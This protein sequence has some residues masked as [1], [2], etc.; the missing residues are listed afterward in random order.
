M[1]TTNQKSTID[2]NTKM[3]VQSKHNTK[4]SRQITKEEIKRRGEK[5]PQ[6]QT[7]NNKM[8]I[9]T[10]I[11]VITLNVNELNTP[12]ERHRLTKWIQKHDPYM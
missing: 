8:T 11:S 9:R 10:H 5:H 7:E 4:D 12:T 1:A 3:K 2:I 6:K